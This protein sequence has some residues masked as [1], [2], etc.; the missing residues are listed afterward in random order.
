[1][2]DH[3][4]NY[5]HLH[6]HLKTHSKDG[7][8]EDGLMIRHLRAIMILG[9]KT[10]HSQLACMILMGNTSKQI[11]MTHMVINSNTLMM[12][13][14]IQ[15]NSIN[16]MISSNTITIALEGAIPE[17]VVV[18]QNLNFRRMVMSMDNHHL[19]EGEGRPNLGLERTGIDV[20]FE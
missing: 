12:I 14:N 3:F 18:L 16:K 20:L 4:N 11:I 5:L 9:Y 10:K 6:L 7:V 8:P 2:V 17:G 1:M 19:G 15:M 13:S